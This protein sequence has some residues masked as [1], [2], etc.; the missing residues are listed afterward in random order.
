[1]I[2]S[3]VQTAY[4]LTN[5]LLE[6]PI[7]VHNLEIKS[8]SSIT[9][10]FDWLNRSQEM[11]L[12]NRMSQ[13]AQ[14]AAI[15]ADLSALRL[16]PERR[17]SARQ[18]ERQAFLERIGA[19]QQAVMSALQPLEQRIDSTRPLARQLL[20]LVAMSAV[21]KADSSTDLM[22]FV[23]QIW[24]LAIAHDQLKP[25]TMQMRM[26]LSRQDALLILADEIDL[27]DFAG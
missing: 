15:K 25:I 4:A 1:M 8:A 9:A 14:L 22:A 21:L 10:C 5:L 6:L 19:M 24:S 17:G 12:S 11:L 23:D 13:A 18:A 20:Q 2:L 27:V 3:P 16:A 26:A 7:I